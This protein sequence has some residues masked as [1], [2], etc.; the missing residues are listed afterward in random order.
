MGT[1]EINGRR[2][3]TS[4]AEDVNLAVIALAK[5]VDEK[6]LPPKML[7]VHRFTYDMLRRY[8]KVRL[9]PRVQVVVVMDGFGNPYGKSKIYRREVSRE[10]VQF[11]GIKLFYKNDVPMMTKKEVLGLKPSPRLVIYQ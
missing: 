10:L 4:D 9:D 8:E 11:A 2:I 3:G 5:L 7:L 1:I 6:R